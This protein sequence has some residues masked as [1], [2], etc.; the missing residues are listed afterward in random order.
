MSPRVRSHAA[1]S[2]IGR[3]RRPRAPIYSSPRSVE[4]GAL[5]RW[6]R[7]A[8]AVEGPEAP[9][10]RRRAKRRRPQRRPPP[11]GAAAVRPDL[12]Y[13]RMLPPAP[14]IQTLPAWASNLGKRLVKT[15]KLVLG[16]SGLAAYLQGL[17]AGRL[18]QGAAA[19][20]SLAE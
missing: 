18:E 19:F 9:A 13:E 5:R 4:A 15:P 16:D 10:T 12:T 20:G 1:R 14:G 11:A 7:C 8:E 6:T 3:R 17:E 2:G